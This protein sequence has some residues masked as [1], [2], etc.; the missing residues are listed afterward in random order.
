MF[1]PRPDRA[2]LNPA[3]S[4]QGGSLRRRA[5]SLALVAALAAAGG[6][7]V[8]LAVAKQTEWLG[9]DETVVVF[10]RSDVS[11]ERPASS[12]TPATRAGGSTGRFDPA[13][14][15]RDRSPGVVTIYA[16]FDD[17]IPGAE[18]QGSGFVVSAQGHVLT[19]AHVIT[20]AGVG[21]SDQAIEAAAEIFVEF[22]DGERVRAE[23]VGWDIF[24]DVGVLQVDSEQHELSPVPLGTS[25]TVTVGEPV[26][27]I[28]SPFG[29]ASS[30][31]V[32][33]VAA[34][35]R[36]INSL[37]SDYSVIDAIQID[38]PINRGNSGGPL[39]NG[40]GEVI[41]INAQIRSASG[42]AEGVGFAV[43][44]DT[45][46]RSMAQLIEEGEVRYPWVGVS[47]ATLTPG[48]AGRL[49]YEVDRGAAIQ[50]VYTDTPASEA[51]LRGGGDAQILDGVP[52]RPDGDVVVAVDGEPISSSEDLIRILAARYRP[53]DAVLLELQRGSER[54]EITV[55]GGER[56][57]DAPREREV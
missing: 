12:S 33:V 52:Y 30:L 11:D 38:A 26:A 34:T 3:P 1:D 37:T 29:Q 2:S 49:G 16:D 6:A 10:S 48:V 28:G 19:N 53:G 32:G 25:S 8:A 24:S 17:E 31:S 4:S 43:P 7:A 47:T 13:A 45:A 5:A 44:I 39:F 9:G 40:S 57:E 14:L 18:A 22:V 41:G 35:G 54:V 21:R 23:V 15:Y 27:A 46:L 36:L 20:T 51:G 56:P 50:R 42:F 55:V